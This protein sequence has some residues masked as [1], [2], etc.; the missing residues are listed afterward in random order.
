MTPDSQ[1]DKDANSQTE[2]GLG[3]AVLD[4]D[5]AILI[6]G[7]DGKIRYITPK[8]ED[9]L[10]L[11]NALTKTGTPMEKVATY[12]L[13]ATNHIGDNLDALMAADLARLQAG[14][15][16]KCEQAPT[17]GRVLE[18][19]RNLLPDGGSLAQYRLQ[20]DW[21]M[22]HEILVNAVEEIPEA[23]VIYDADGCLVMCNQHFRDMYSYTRE[24]TAPGTHFR[25]LGEIDV[26]R[27]NVAVPDMEEEEYLKRKAE[28]RRALKGSF[29]VHLKDG[30]RILTRD[31]RTAGGGFVSIQSDVTDSIK[32]QESLRAAKEAADIAATAKSN[33]LANISHELRS[34][35]NAIIGFAEVIQS[36]QVW[37]D[38]HIRFRDYASDI[39]QAGK[40]LLELINDIIDVAKLKTGDIKMHETKISVADSITSAI[41]RVEERAFAR[42]VN[43]DRPVDLPHLYLRADERQVKQMLVNL[44]TNAIKFTPEGGRISVTAEKNDGQETA[45]TVTDTG[46]G[47]AEEYID[48]VT[49]AF[50]QIDEGADRRHPGTGIGLA[51][52]KGM[53]ELH[54][55]RIEI[56]S[57]LG[58][59]TA[60]RLIFPQ[61]RSL[62]HIEDDPD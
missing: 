17:P 47:I 11:P 59:G 7:P 42:G 33:F 52:V 10:G 32:L 6:C 37:P 44:L 36:E 30:R 58:E 53:M 1:N 27:G 40:Y 21:R 35:L 50:R 23:F 41:G 25:T 39:H 24:E 49:E 48:G 20:T 45:I 51:L 54:D 57:K 14:E 3:Q 5:L 19:T 31:R 2:H 28:Y 29:L 18:V 8:A 46:T 15:V 61:S 26:K 34:P 60:V 16:M 4:A 55:G 38:S 22:L 62:T 9:L 12:L 43:L 56:A 13:K